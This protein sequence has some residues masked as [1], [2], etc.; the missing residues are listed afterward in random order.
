MR[1]KPQRACGGDWIDPKLA[2][3]SGFVAAAVDF[4]MVSAAERNGKLVADLTAKRAVLGEPQVMRI[5]GC[6]TANETGLCRHVPDMLAVSDSTGFGQSKN[7][8]V[9]PFRPLSRPALAH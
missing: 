9:D 4:T 2:P 8:L 1:L 6:A 5:T 7:A 3:P